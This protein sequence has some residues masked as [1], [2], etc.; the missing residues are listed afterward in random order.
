M[1]ARTTTSLAAAGHRLRPLGLAAAIPIASAIVGGAIGQLLEDPGSAPAVAILALAVGI[2]AVTA[3]VVARGAVLDRARPAFAPTNAF[4]RELDRARRHGRSF[5][6]VRLHLG[7]PS[8]GGRRHA[9]GGDGIAAGTVEL[10]GTMLRI[11][12]LA[13][14]EDDTIVVL[15]PESDRATAEAFLARGRV[16]A[17]AAFA[18]PAGIAM[19]PDDGLTS[20]ALLDSSERHLVGEPRPQPMLPTLIGS[21]DALTADGTIQLETGIG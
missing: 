19:F 5:A 6:L 10:L 12:D 8:G 11:T 2:L 3:V 20:G 18:G 14:I 17:P 7:A 15:L 13:W 1:T 16:A 21:P 4:R 9:A